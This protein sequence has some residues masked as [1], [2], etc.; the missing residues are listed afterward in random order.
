MGGKFQETSEKFKDHVPYF[1]R[2]KR[3]IKLNSYQ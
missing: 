1:I 3:M 2:S